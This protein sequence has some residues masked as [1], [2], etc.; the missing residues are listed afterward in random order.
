MPYYFRR[1]HYCH[2]RLRHDI[3][4]HISP[5]F[6]LLP[7]RHFPRFIIFAISHIFIFQ[8]SCH[9]AAIDRHIFAADASPPFSLARYYHHFA[10]PLLR[11]QPLLF[12]PR[13]HYFIFRCR[14]HFIIYYFSHFICHFFD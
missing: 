10:T 3:T 2:F 6:S 11:R 9:Y 1:C 13:F 5:L 4:P 8:L 12:S 14:R 7:F